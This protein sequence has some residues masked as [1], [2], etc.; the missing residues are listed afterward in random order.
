VRKNYEVGMTARRTRRFTADD[1]QAFAGV[2]GDANPVHLD[3]DY[4]AATSFGQRIVH[5]MLT[6]SLISAIIGNDLPGEG[7]IYMR[8]DLQFKA[9]VYLGDT[10]TA[11]V[12]IT[13]IREKRGII[14][15]ATTC[16]NQGQTPVLTGEAV[17][18]VPD[19]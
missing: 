7:A 2:T 17:V 12:E 16:T 18:M 1:V 6:A 14:T 10:I 19:A 11:T 5:G 9:P 3:D 4:A 8:Q 13:H 15:L